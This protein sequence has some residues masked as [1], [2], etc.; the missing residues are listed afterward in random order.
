MKVIDIFDC[1]YTEDKKYGFIRNAARAVIRDKGKL[2]VEYASTPKM[3][4]LPGG[5]VENCENY[6]EC[7]VRECKE[8]CGIAV[9][10]VKKLF[11]IREYYHEMIFY[12][13][14]ILCE[15]IGESEKSLTDNEKSLNMI[16]D[17]QDCK[18]L[19]RQLSELMDEYK[20]VDEELYGCHK[21]EYIAIKEITKILNIQ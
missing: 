10:P 18:V 13:V 1:N 11:A 5:G 2:F 4:M 16:C 8:E 15:I 12:S 19:E 3:L 20:D 7:V 17:W 9:K 6:D 21:R 14:Y